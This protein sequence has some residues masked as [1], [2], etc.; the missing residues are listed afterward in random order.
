[1]DDGSLA[2]LTM[3]CDPALT[4][5]GFPAPVVAVAGIGDANADGCDEIAFGYHDATHGGV[6]VTFGF[7]VGGV[8][9]GGRTVP[10]S[11]RISADADTAETYLGL[12][13]AV[14]NVGRFLGGTTPWLAVGATHVPFAGGAR[15]GVMLLDL[16]QIVALR[17]ASGSA[18]T[19][20]AATGITTNLVGSVDPFDGLGSALVGGIDLTGDGVVDLVAGAPSAS[21]AANGSGVALV[22]A[23]GATSTGALRPWALVAGDDGNTAAG[24]GRALALLPAGNSRPAMLGIGSPSS[25]RSGAGNGAAFLLSLP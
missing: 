25:G 8:R 7:D 23:G 17:P 9:C 12:G 5:S 15:A 6:V 14:A 21:F 3:G 18:A 20:L 2:K 1:A 11:V 19:G 22:F 16:S 24:L 10:S 4:L 13:T